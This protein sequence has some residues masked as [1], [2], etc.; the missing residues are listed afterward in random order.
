[1]VC[2]LFMLQQLNQ[3]WV[4][5]QQVSAERAQTLGSAFEVQR[6]HRYGELLVF[7]LWLEN[8]LFVVS[9]LMS[10][11]I[12]ITSEDIKCIAFYELA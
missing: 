5:L 10:L 4:T 8:V 9:C 3:R 6:Y 2:F 7:C 1:M 12:D 11:H